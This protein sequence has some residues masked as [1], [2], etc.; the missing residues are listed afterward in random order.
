M[1]IR[2]TTRAATPTAS[3]I[4]KA[5]IKEAVGAYPPLLLFV[6]TYTQSNFTPEIHRA[7]AV[8]RPAAVHFGV[9]NTFYSVPTIENVGQFIFWNIADLFAVGVNPDSGASLKVVFFDRPLY[10]FAEGF[11]APFYFP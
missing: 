5:K 10:E 8:V 6:F 1:S 7:S 4:E 3:D 2:R 9:V 11:V